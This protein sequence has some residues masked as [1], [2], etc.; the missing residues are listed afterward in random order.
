MGKQRGDPHPRVFFVRVANEGL[1]LD[2]SHF[3][4]N[5][6]QGRATGEEVDSPDRTG[7][8]DRKLEVERIGKG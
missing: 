3:R 8:F 5:S 7:S 1:K 2:A 6:R 4:V